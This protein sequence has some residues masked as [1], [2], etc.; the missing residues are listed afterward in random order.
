MLSRTFVSYEGD[1]GVLLSGGQWQRLALARALLRGHRELLI[2]D[3]PS[4][5]LDARA[6]HLIHREIT[7]H[8][9]GRTSVLVSH[10]LSAVR[11]ADRILVLAGGRIVE[12]GDHDSLIAA[13]G[14]YA[15]LF[16]LQAA[17]YQVSP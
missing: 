8:R 17:G 15:E 9:Q 5:G 7:A 2:L 11:D 4:S 14:S 12:D 6:E 13:D 10:R 1:D 16:H 3:E